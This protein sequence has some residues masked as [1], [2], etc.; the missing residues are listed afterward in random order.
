MRKILHIWFSDGYDASITSITLEDLLRRLKAREQVV[1]TTVTT[2]SKDLLDIID[3]CG[4]DM[5]GHDT[6]IDSTNIKKTDC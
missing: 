2:Y 4:Y 5:I 1:H 3:K 6:R